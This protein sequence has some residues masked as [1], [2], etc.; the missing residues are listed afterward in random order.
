[1]LEKH[2]L[3]TEKDQ[4]DFSTGLSI[5]FSVAGLSGRCSLFYPKNP[6]T[7]TFVMFDSFLHLE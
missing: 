7:Y 4:R 1:M 3:P 2:W 6:P 5:T